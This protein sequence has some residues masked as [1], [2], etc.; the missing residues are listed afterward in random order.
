VLLADC[1]I[2]DSSLDFW[3]ASVS[4]SVKRANGTCVIL[5]CCC[6]QSPTKTFKEGRV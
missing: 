6:D 1:V 3:V 4:S 5:S 2:L